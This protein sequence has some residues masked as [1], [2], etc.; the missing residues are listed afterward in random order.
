MAENKKSLQIELQR[1]DISGFTVPRE[2][3]HVVT[4]ELIWPRFLVSSRSCIRTLK[5]EKGIVD[6][7]HSRWLDRILFKE[8]VEH[9]FGLVMRISQSL[10]A[11]LFDEIMR[12]IGGSLFGIVGSLAEK[13][14]GTEA[15]DLAAS[16]FLF[17][18]KKLL[19]SH[20]AEIILEG[21][22]DL[23]TADLAEDSTVEIPLISQVNR[24]ENHIS[25]GRGRGGMTRKRVIAVGTSL[26][27]ATLRIRTLK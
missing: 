11:A 13:E 8:T 10:T 3:R 9:T 6:L 7:S 5:L 20:E 12:T 21:G 16:P 14:V 19:A 23:K 2:S 18:R 24:Y 17:V 15:G 26:G 4:T 25:P 27:S 22:I 1:L